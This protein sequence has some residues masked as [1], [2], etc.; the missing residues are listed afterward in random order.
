[1]RK[2]FEEVNDINFIEFQ[3]DGEYF[4]FFIEFPEQK[5]ANVEL[6]FS[7][8]QILEMI[9]EMSKLLIK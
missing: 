8:N 9:S 3:N 5:N 6:M 7:Q 1:M 2:I 4:R